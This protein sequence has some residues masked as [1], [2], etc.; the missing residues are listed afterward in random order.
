MSAGEKQ[1]GVSA[2][3]CRRSAVLLVAAALAGCSPQLEY[4]F[5]QRVIE[6]G[7]EGTNVTRAT[8]AL[9]LPVQLEEADEL[10]ERTELAT[11]LGV[12]VPYVRID[13]VSVAIE[14]TVKNLSGDECEATVRVN[15]ANEFYYVEPDDFEIDPEEEPDPQSLLG[16]VPRIIEPHGM[17][18]GVYPEHEVREAALDIELIT[19][20]GYH[21]IAAVLGA[22][23]GIDELTDPV[24]GAIVPEEVFAGIVRLD[25]DLE[26]TCHMVL[27][28]A[29]RVRDHGDIVH[30][31]LFAAPP[32]ELTVFA[33]VEVPPPP[34]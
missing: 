17:F 13:D 20:G 5:P 22:H 24:T 12:E 11:E 3:N 30:D 19:R 15:G 16:G 8:A 1:I 23:E 33:P 26:A 10:T 27:E 32:A 6:V 18:S 14:W 29:V 2:A 21:P 31:D 34:D 25:F 28:Y 7:A 4:L 9:V